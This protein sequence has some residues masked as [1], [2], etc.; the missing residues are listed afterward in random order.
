VAAAV[1]A[2]DLDVLA[3]ADDVAAVAECAPTPQEAT[4]LAAYARNEPSLATLS[5]AELFCYR[6]MEVRLLILQASHGAVGTVSASSC[7]LTLL[8]LH[9]TCQ[10]AHPPAV[11]SSAVT[12]ICPCPGTGACRA[13]SGMYGPLPVATGAPGCCN[14]PQQAS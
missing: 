1:A 2:L 3:S 6:L 8:L 14:H 12:V 4:L 11:S 9:T 10:D 5:N 7:T 13:S